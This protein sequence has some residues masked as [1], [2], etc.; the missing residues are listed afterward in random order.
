MTI[1]EIKRKAL[2]ILKKYDL[3]K[4]GVFGSIVRGELREDSDV[5]ILVEIGKDDMSLLDF[6]GIKL[7]IEEALG[8]KVDLVEY[9]T[10]KPLL[11]ERILAE[12]VPIL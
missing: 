3:R 12:E 7:E 1:D 2:P 10:I 5:D 9:D 6:V 8:R 11:K 4:A